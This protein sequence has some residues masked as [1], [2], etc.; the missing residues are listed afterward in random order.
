MKILSVGFVLSLG[1]DTATE[2]L[3]VQVKLCREFNGTLVTAFFLEIG[4]EIGD[5]INFA[6]SLSNGVQN[7]AVFLGTY[8]KGSC[9]VVKVILFGDNGTFLYSHSIALYTSCTPFGFV[10]KTF[11]HFI[12]LFGFISALNEF[13]SRTHLRNQ[14][15]NFADTVEI[16]AFGGDIRVIEKYGYVKVFCEI[17]QNITTARGTTRMKQQFRA[18]IFGSDFFKCLIKFKLIIRFRHLFHCL[19]P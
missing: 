18:D 9:E 13:H 16:F 12:E 14:S 3:S 4:I 2:I 11:C 17:L 8:G 15:F 10:F 6:Y 1:V 5:I 19:S 7:M